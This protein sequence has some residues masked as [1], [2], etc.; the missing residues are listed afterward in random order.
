M[1]ATVYKSTGNWYVVKEI[2]DTKVPESLKK[3][4]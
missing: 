3:F 1:K 4:N 2:D